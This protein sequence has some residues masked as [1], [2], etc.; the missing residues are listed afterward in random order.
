MTSGSAQRPTPP[1]CGSPWITSPPRVGHRSDLIHWRDP[2]S[3]TQWANFNDNRLEDLTD[4]Q[5]GGRGQL[6]V[7]RDAL[8][9]AHRELLGDGRGL[10]VAAGLADLVETG[11]GISR[12]VG[13]QEQ[14]A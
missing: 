7:L 9:L 13:V 10:R 5:L 11:P 6:Q 4:G 14:V 8:L 2:R 1:T 12:P 3:A